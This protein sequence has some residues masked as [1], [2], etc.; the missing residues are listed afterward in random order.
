MSHNVITFES[1]EIAALEIR[2]ARN[3]NEYATGVLIVRN[4]EGAFESSHPFRTFD[5]A[6]V[7][8]T[9]SKQNANPEATG[10]D[11]AFDGEDAETRNRKPAKAGK[12][13]SG[14]V[15]GWFQTKPDTKNVWRTT[16]VFETLNLK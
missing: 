4:N 13:L 8:K 16:F 7:L 12:R 10:G 5:H 6:D 2:T 11:L 14:S 3:G 15:T 1:A 9:L